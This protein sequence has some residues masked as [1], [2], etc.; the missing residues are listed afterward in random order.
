MATGGVGEAGAGGWCRSR[1]CLTG[2]LPRFVLFAHG[3][4]LPSS[5]AAGAAAAHIR[6]AALPHTLIL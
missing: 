4:V 6:P 1:G 3:H 2:S 5:S